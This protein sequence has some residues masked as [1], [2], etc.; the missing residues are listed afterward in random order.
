MSPPIEH[1]FLVH[2]SDVRVLFVVL[3]LLAFA[4]PETFALGEILSISSPTGGG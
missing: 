2:T 3:L 4:F 1:S